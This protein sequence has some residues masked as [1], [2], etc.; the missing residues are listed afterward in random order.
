MTLTEKQLDRLS[1]EL[2][3]AGR[4]CT[5]VD[6]LTDRFPEISIPEAYVIQLR[7]VQT[8]V[9]NGEVIVGKKIGLCSKAM[10]ELLGVNEPDYGHILNTMVVPQDQP[11]LMTRLIQPRIEGEVCFVLKDDL[12]GPGI[13]SAMVLTA[14]AGIMPA[15]EVIDSRFKGWKIKIQD[16]IADNAS[17]ALVVL[18][19]QMTSVANLD[20]RLVGMVLEK[21]GETIATGAGAAVLG[22]PAQAVAWLA[23]KLNEY[24]ITLRKGEFI[25]SGSLTSAMDIE[26]GSCFRATFDR[27]GSVSAHFVG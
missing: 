9:N 10:Q 23:N 19:S 11:I 2:I 14:T 1:Q 25:M 20:F 26:A 7:M 21:N 8:K 4:T 17:S 18:G 13:T 15:L 12:R 3:E 22:N 6:N 5:P 27:L 16:T 24:G